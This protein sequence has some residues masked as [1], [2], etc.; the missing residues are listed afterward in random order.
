MFLGQREFTATTAGSRQAG[1]NC[2]VQ[3]VDGRRAAR[4]SYCFTKIAKLLTCW[5]A[6]LNPTV[7][8]PNIADTI[9]AR[10][11]LFVFLEVFELPS[12]SPPDVFSRREAA[13]ERS[14]A[15]FGPAWEWDSTT[16]APQIL[17]GWGFFN[18]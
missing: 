6:R 14:A 11:W 4:R 9:A 17:R 18:L 1:R 3:Y 10:F 15:I 7:Y 13:V 8:P 2:C 16:L 12:H 5:R